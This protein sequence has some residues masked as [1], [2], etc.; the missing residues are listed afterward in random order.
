MRFS[1]KDMIMALTVTIPSEV[2]ATV[3]KRAAARGVDPQGFVV[4]V[5][6]HQ[7]APTPKRPANTLDAEETRLFQV[8]NKPVPQKSRD[9]YDE[10]L[11]KQKRSRL[12]R[13]DDDELLRLTN[14]MEKNQARRIKAVGELAAYRG[15]DFDDLW[16]QLGL[17]TPR[18]E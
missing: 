11:K 17:G 10:L 8:I 18:H 1:T 13:F 15:V 14:L 2:E 6:R 12:S 4:D 16:D 7:F 9:L 3:R 5:L